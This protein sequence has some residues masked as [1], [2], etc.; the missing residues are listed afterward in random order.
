MPV[1]EALP[2]LSD[3]D[4]ECQRLQLGMEASELHGGLSGWL[5]GG[6][7][8]RR[9]WLAAVLADDSL[10]V[11]TED[12]VLDQLCVATAGQLADEDFGFS[13][14]LPDEDASLY[15]R[16]EALFAWCR[17]FVGAFGLAAGGEPPLSEEGLEALADLVKLGAGTAQ[18]GGDDEDEAAFAEIEEFVRV[19]A[20]LLYGDCVAGPSH[21]RRLN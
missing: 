8:D 20:L 3:V 19:A 16:S 18:P 11:V 1:S 13:L 10:P 21:R 6:G 17:G 12:S 15:E 4:A 9:Q 5:A 7:D 2:L 14:L